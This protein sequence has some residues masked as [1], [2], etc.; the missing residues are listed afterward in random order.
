MMF[1]SVTSWSIDL[2][3][4]DFQSQ[5]KI[6]YS[7]K[8][9]SE[10]IVYELFSAF[11]AN[12]IS[13]AKLYNIMTDFDQWPKLLKSVKDVKWITSK[14]TIVND[15]TIRHHAKYKVKA[16]WPVRWIEAEESSFY[17]QT[18]RDETHIEYTFYPD[19]HFTQVGTKLKEGHAELRWDKETH[20]IH[21]Y[22]Y[23]E[24]IP[25]IDLLMKVT[26]PYVAKSMDNI[27]KGL[28]EK[29]ITPP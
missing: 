5:Y 28:F 4:P 19:S 26:A 27:F 6:V 23:I 10:M 14:K 2:T 11:D 1:L 8:R 24:I 25:Q 15:T 16:P 21:G 20:L 7:E 22:L 17:I 3:K 13:L 29:Y 12:K 9:H 18:R